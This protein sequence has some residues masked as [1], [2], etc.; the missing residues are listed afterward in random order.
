MGKGKG[1]RALSLQVISF[2][3]FKL[4][5]LFSKDTDRAALTRALHQLYI[6][7]IRLY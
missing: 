6:L 1:R 5:P 2:T 7:F 4:E 3:T